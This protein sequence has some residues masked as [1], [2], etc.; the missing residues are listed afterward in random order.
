VVLLQ[1][2]DLIQDLLHADLVAGE[3]AHVLGV[4][5]EAC[6]VQP[7][8]FPT[9]SF[10]QPSLSAPEVGRA[11]A[12]GTGPVDPLAA[13]IARAGMHRSSQDRSSGPAVRT[14]QPGTLLSRLMEAGIRGQGTGMGAAWQPSGTV[15]G[16]SN[17]GTTGSRALDRWGTRKEGQSICHLMEEA[18]KAC[19]QVKTRWPFTIG[20]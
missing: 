4:L 8:I 9:R 6:L 1:V 19:I 5:A 13:A 7:W 15:L 12:G 16:R 18:S 3:L 11:D 17:M 14:H 10:D 20:K 2:D